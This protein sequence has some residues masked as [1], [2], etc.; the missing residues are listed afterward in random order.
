MLLLPSSLLSQRI[1]T[2]VVQDEETGE[3]LPYATVG[4]RKAG[5]GTVTDGEGQ[6]LIPLPANP[7]TL[8]V[9]FLGY[10]EFKLPVDSST[11]FEEGKIIGLKAETLS[12]S[13][14]EI[15]ARKGRYRRKGNPA[16]ALIRKVIENKERNQPQSQPYYQ[17][18][19]YEKVE[20]G[21]VNFTESFTQRKIWKGYKFVFDYIDSTSFEK[22]VL[23]LF[24][25]ES[26]TTH[27]FRQDPRFKLSLQ[28]GLKVSKPEKLITDQSVKEVFSRLNQS[29]DLYQNQIK[30]FELEFVSPIADIAPLFY[31]YYLGD[32]VVVQ[33]T[34]CAV[35]DF[36]P[37]NPYS[38]GFTGSLFI[39]LD[40]TFQ[41]LGVRMEVPKTVNVNFM[42]SLV[43]EQ[44]F[45]LK[46]STWVVARDRLEATLGLSPASLSLLGQRTV[47]YTDHQFAPAQDPEIYQYKTSNAVLP[48]NNKRSEAFWDSLRTVPL[49]EREANIYQMVDSL[50]QNRSFI[51]LINLIKTAGSGHFELGPFRIGSLYSLLSYNPVEGVRTRLGIQTNEKFHNHWRL[52]G[53]AAY[54]FGDKRVKFGGRVEY[55][56]DD[57]LSLFPRHFIHLRVQDENEFPGQFTSFL[58]RDNIFFSYQI[59]VADKM[60]NFRRLELQYHKEFSPSFGMDL[61]LEHREQRAVG[62]WAFERYSEPED[63]LNEVDRIKTTTAQISLFFAPKAKWVETQN[64][65]YIIPNTTPWVSVDYQLGFDGF[66]GGEHHFHHLTLGLRQRIFMGPAGFAVYHI[67]LGKLWGKEIPFPLVH[68]AES[69]Q[70]ISFSPRAYNLMNFMEFVGDEHASLMLEYHLSG[71]ILNRIPLIRK[72]KLREVFGF[73][74]YYGRLTAANNPNLNRTL[75]QFPRNEQGEAET[76]SITGSPYMEISAGFTNILKVFRIDYVQRLSYRDHPNLPSLFGLKGAGIRVG[77]SLQF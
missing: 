68:I 77:L 46:D 48:D 72:L 64:F 19:Q 44:D 4:Y 50:N 40:S 70:T 27:Y 57:K 8:F 20:V 9:L 75:I 67:R 45:I 53:Y 59:G 38:F 69:N 16:V 61:Y 12:L 2:G 56:F 39:A 26:T 62:N 74:L 6:F 58:N 13:T 10:E 35:L 65:R 30:L 63:R 66:L 73:K 52:G 71:L 21:L 49:N 25:Q 33:E 34:S 28:T 14:V 18:D 36:V 29:V 55:S 60:L 32:T 17:Y 54:G 31:R 1:L 42:Q 47:F 11:A 51:R 15:A 5:I 22:P 23:P 7:D 41:V 3:P 43:L 24:L 76:Y 37:A